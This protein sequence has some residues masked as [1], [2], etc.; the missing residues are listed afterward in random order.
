MIYRKNLNS[1]N[2]GY[3]KTFEDFAKEL[4]NEIPQEGDK[5]PEK[6]SKIILGPDPQNSSSPTSQETNVGAKYPNGGL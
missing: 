3:L 6:K 4:K 5:K 2:N 1:M